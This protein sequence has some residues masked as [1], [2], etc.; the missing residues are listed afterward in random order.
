MRI[1][2]LH[3]SHL[4]R[5]GLIAL[6]REALLAQAVIAERTKG[7]RH[8]PQLIR[9]RNY[10]N[11][12]ALI[13]SYLQAIEQEAKGR[14][15][16]FDESRILVSEAADYAP[17]LSVTAGQLGFEWAHLGAKLAARSP[18]DAQRWRISTPTPH[19][20]FEV[21]PGGIE[22]WERL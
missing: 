9:F 1:W 11:P 19:P 22:S 2:S 3:P 10:S 8:H 6:W 18:D 4:D 13:G 21:V 15:Y 14:G 16:R 7:Y 17:K 12:L 20:L 5:S